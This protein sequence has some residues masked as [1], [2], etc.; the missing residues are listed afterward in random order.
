MGD[1]IKIKMKTQVVVK[2]DIQQEPLKAGDVG[3]IDG[4]VRAADGRAYAIVI[5]GANIGYAPI[6]SISPTGRFVK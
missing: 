4:Y 6:N 5:C 3:Y 2:H 1:K